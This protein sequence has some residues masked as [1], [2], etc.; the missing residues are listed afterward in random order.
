MIL[1]LS[2]KPLNELKWQQPN[3]TLQSTFLESMITDV[4]KIAIDP[5]CKMDV[6]TSTANLMSEYNGKMYYFCNPYCKD[7]FDTNPEE[8][9]DKDHR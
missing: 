4:P 1:I 5:I 6:D 2:I 9:K 8:W 7:T 3:D